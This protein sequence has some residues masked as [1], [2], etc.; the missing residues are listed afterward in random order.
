MKGV[1]RPATKQSRLDGHFT[2]RRAVGCC[3]AT[4]KRPNQGLGRCPAQ[5]VDSRR[6]CAFFAV[7]RPLI[8]PF[9]RCRTAQGLT[10]PSRKP[11]LRS[12]SWT[13]A[14]A[15]QSPPGARRLFL[16]PARS[17]FSTRRAAFEERVG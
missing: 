6:N 9:G 13:P 17:F 5:V 7:A 12:Y 15:Y 3:P 10:N 11:D 1:R 4:A 8:W 2:S 16:T 14:N